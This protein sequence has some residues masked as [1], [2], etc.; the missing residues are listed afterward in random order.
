MTSFV[1]MKNALANGL[2]PTLWRTC[3]IL[4][5]TKR[6]QLLRE[7]YQRPGRCVKELGAAVGVK[8]SD[9]SQELRRLQSRGLLKTHRQGILLIYHLEADP[10]VPS[11]APLLRSLQTALHSYPPKQDVE[12]IHMARGL[13]N[14]RRLAIARVLLDQSRTNAE[15][16]RRLSLSRSALSQHLQILLESGFIVKQRYVYCFKTPKHPVGRTLVQLLRQIR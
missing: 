2:N 5:G 11:A 8:R 14:E 12:I 15:L 4:A 1:Y 6:V 3:R 16:Q 10:Q 9:A 7:L 13:A